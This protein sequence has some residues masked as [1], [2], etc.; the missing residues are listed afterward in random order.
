MEHDLDPEDA[1]HVIL[2]VFGHRPS[3]EVLGLLAAGPLEDLIEYHGEQF[4]DRIESEARESEAFKQLLCGVWPSHS[5]ELWA[6][7]ED[8]RGVKAPPPKAVLHLYAKWPENP[9]IIDQAAVLSSVGHE[10]SQAML[11]NGYLSHSP[12]RIVAIDLD[13]NTSTNHGSSRDWRAAGMN[14]VST[15]AFSREVMV[16]L[17]RE[18]QRMVVRDAV[19]GFLR[20]AALAFGLPSGFLDSGRR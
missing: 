18:E 16:Q 3:E 20:Q 13:F 12:F 4:I 15:I 5:K 7:V 9:A 8:A 6:R 10:L 11:A 1:W 14:L 17:G 2:R 19:M